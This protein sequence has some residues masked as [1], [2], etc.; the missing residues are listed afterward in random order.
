V[1]AQ[2]LQ[3]VIVRMLFDPAFRQRVY[4]EPAAALR[5]VELTAEERQWLI[6]PPPQA[7][8]TDVHRRS[9]ALSGLLEEYPVAGALA[10]R[11]R[12]GL[13]R[14]Q[15][16]FASAFFHQCVQQRGSMAE[17]FGDYLQSA[18]FAEQPE[19]ARMAVIELGIVRVRRA[20]DMP[21]PPGPAC[22]TD[23]RLRL[24]PWVVLLT[25]PATAL[26]RYSTLLRRLRQ[27]RASLLEAVLDATYRLPA[28]PAARAGATEWVLVV[29][30]PGGDGPSLEAT[31]R[32]LGALLSAAQHETTFGALCAQAV[33]LG[34]T[35]GEAREVL[36]GLL[37]DRLLMRAS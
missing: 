32:E 34:A 23:T 17:A 25:A 36:E 30:V 8:G 26:P 31:S 22:T 15:E 28:A 37:A 35:A 20:P 21:P 1:S 24:A 4:A 14:L 6:T 19:I 2:A 5:D 29:G 18:V 12:Q 3:R 7:Y 10:V 11:G 9:R 16:F 27:Y 33:G 13:A